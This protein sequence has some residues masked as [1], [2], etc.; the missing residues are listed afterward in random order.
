MLESVKKK[1][2][3]RWKKWQQFFLTRSK[4]ASLIEGHRNVRVKKCDGQSRDEIVPAMRE[5]SGAQTA[6]KQSK[7]TEERAERLRA[8]TCCARL[9]IHAPHRTA[10][11][12]N[13][14]PATAARHAPTQ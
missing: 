5:N 8:E 12:E 9:R 6:A 11:A 4:C 1:T 2:T 3:E 10:I 14:T 7:Q 13:T